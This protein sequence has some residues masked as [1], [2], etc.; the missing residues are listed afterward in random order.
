M[1]SEIVVSLGFVGICVVLGAKLSV[2][3]GIIERPLKIGIWRSHPPLTIVAVVVVGGGPLGV[4]VWGVMVVVVERPL[5][6]GV[7]GPGTPLTM[8]MTI[9]VFIVIGVVI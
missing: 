5:G 1:I 6:I 9:V 2:L 8:T 4:G 3:I 7:W